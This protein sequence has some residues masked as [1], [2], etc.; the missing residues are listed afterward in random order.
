M[1]E[2]LSVAARTHSRKCVEVAR[3]V[4]HN[5]PFVG[6]IRIAHL[7]PLGV[8]TITMS[9]GLHE[10]SRGVQE[11]LGALLLLGARDGCSHVDPP[12]GG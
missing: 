1:C 2:I 10:S 11:S 12:V 7:Q 9:R 5:T 3:N 8:A 4:S 6:T